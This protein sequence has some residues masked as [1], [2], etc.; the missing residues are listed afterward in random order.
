MKQRITATHN[1]NPHNRFADPVQFI[2][3]CPDRSKTKRKA[4]RT[5]KNKE[6]HNRSS[7]QNKAVQIVETSSKSRHTQNLHIKCHCGGPRLHAR[8]F[9]TL[10][11]YRNSSRTA[12]CDSSAHS[13]RKFEPCTSAQVCITVK[14]R[15]VQ[16]DFTIPSIPR[17]HIF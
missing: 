8:Y 16:T 11:K 6:Q 15:V 17:L 14:N 13:K 2:R 3:K 4:T 5:H 12:T 10:S 7:Q 1:S 9:M